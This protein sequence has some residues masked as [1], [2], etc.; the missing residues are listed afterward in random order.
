MMPMSLCRKE[1]SNSVGA[2]GG[3]IFSSRSR[4]EVKGPT[5]FNNVGGCVNRNKIESN[6]NRME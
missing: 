2:V 6:A 5:M 3:G 4:L 1:H